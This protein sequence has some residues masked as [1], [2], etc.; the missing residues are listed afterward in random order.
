[1]SWEGAGRWRSRWTRRG[2]KGEQKEKEEEEE[3]EDGVRRRAKTTISEYPCC[4]LS[5]MNNDNADAQSRNG[6][7]ALGLQRVHQ[8]SSQ[9]INN[10]PKELNARPATS[11]YVCNGFAC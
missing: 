5:F 2:G 3:D 11:K 7:R 10:T 4:A 9:R 6:A 8:E 1:M